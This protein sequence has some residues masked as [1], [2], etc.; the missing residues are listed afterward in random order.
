MKRSLIIT[1][2]LLAG[3]QAVAQPGLVNDTKTRA[4]L[5]FFYLAKNSQYN[6]DVPAPQDVLNYFTGERFVE[7][8]DVLRYVDVLDRTSARVSYKQFGKTF[9]G[10]PFIQVYIT[11][12]ENQTKLESIRLEHLRVTDAN[13]SSSIALDNMPIVIDIMGSIHGN[14]ASGVNAIVPLMYFYAASEDNA[15]KELLDNAVLIF[16]PGQNPDGLNRFATNVNNYSSYNAFIANNSIKEHSLPWP[17][18]RSNHYWMDVNR[19]WLT[20]QMPEGRNLVKMYEYWMPNVVLDLHEQGAGKSGEYYFSPGDANRTH[21]CIPQKNQD[22]TEQISHYTEHAIDSVGITYFSKKG[23]DDFFIG[24][25][26]CYG[27]VQGSV[28]ILHEQSGTYGHVRDFGERG[29]R[30]FAQTVRNQAIASMAV[31]NGAYDLR[32]D[33]KA[34]QRDFYVNAAKEAEKNANKGYTF[35]ARGNKGIAFHFI[36]NLLLHEIDVY[37]VAGQSDTWF[38]PFNQR[39]YKKLLTIFDD[40]TEY[41]SSKF[42]DISTWGPVYAYNLKRE[43]V[44]TAPETGAKITVNTLPQGEVTG[45]QSPVAYVFSLA[46]YYTPYMMSALQK[47]GVNIKVAVKPFEYKYK[48]EKIN[49]TF[50]AGTAVITVAGQTISAEALYSAVSEVA[51]K[52]AVN[53]EALKV[54]K[55]RGFDISSVKMKDVRDPKIILAADMGG[56]Q[57]IGETWYILDYRYDLRHYMM[58]IR[59]LNNPQFP[60]DDYDVIIFTGG[61]PSKKEMAAAY[62]NIEKWVKNGG[63]LILQ[64]NGSFRAAENIGAGKSTIEEAKGISG[65]I[66]NAD[67]KKADSPL[68]WGYDQEQIPVF[69]SGAETYKF[70]DKASVVLAWNSE[71]PYL[72]GYVSEANLARIKSTPVVA[73]MSVGKG[74]IVFI[75]EDLNFRSYWYG[76][77]HILTNAI[78]FGN[79]L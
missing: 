72:T 5:E 71:N 46:E 60:I 19:D 27:D 77:T 49:K 43:L 36:E 30:T 59:K 44:A 2:L 14:E 78:F 50:P 12:P 8:G 56:S 51:A 41:S 73:T 29:I 48:A 28:C 39:H 52:C 66:M 63:T 11:S 70:P 69:K 76:T 18:P 53:V 21:Y 47:K 26:A 1:A 33:I 20:A 40:I 24:K 58:D 23:Y 34:Y 65:L 54:D 79:M 15:V 45:G 61:A 55:R 4:D 67:V 42:Y 75:A 35:S 25:G 10:R 62:A 32:N 17:S 13:V 64:Q 37:P 3:L 9:E 68:L 57:S 6:P 16:T 74:S 22:L 31:I 38:V 7:W